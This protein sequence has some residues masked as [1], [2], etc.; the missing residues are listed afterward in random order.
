MLSRWPVP[1]SAADEEEEAI[2]SSRK[3]TETRP[4]A[5]END[6]AHFVEA[7]FE[8][9][10][11]RG[12]ARTLLH[13]RD[14]L[15]LGGRKQRVTILMSDLRGFTPLAERM[16]PEGVMRLLNSYL[17]RMT[18]IIFAFGGTIIEF[19]GDAIFALFGLPDPSFDDARRAVACALEMQRAMAEVNLAAAAEGSPALEM[20]IGLDTG[21]VVVGNI[22][23]EL[24]AKYGAVGSHVNLSA[25][26]QAQAAGGRVMVT[27]STRDA[28]G[29]GLVVCASALIDAKGF[30]EPVRVHD[31]RGIVGGGS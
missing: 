28:A 15:K 11:G 26:I 3:A 2:A 22:G 6:N 30:A 13:T 20:A 29:G 17:G 25:R 5:G 7:T 27:D 16:D 18:R 12:V 31:V 10:V 14:G 23:S 9:Y 21:D 19:I 1:L 8:R 24:R 4:I